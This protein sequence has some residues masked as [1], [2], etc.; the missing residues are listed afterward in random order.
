MAEEQIQVGATCLT[1]SSHFTF[2]SVRTDANS[3]VLQ[4]VFA[5]RY[6][7]YCLERKFL[8]VEPYPDGLESDEYDQC[9]THFAACNR[10]DQVVGTLRLI[11]PR[12]DQV[13][14]F[15]LF[16]NALYENFA[17]PPKHESGEV[18][19]L[20]VDRN[21]H[22]RKGDTPEGI[23]QEFLQNPVPPKVMNHQS[24]PTE[25]RSNS[26]EILLGLY[27]QLYHHALETGVRYWYAA[28]EQSLARL[29][30]RV[31]FTFHPIGFQTEY[32]GP[33]TPFVADLRELESSLAARNPELFAWFL[34]KE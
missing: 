8:P 29:L 9:S 27:R 32:Y 12:D 22:R 24:P 1:N 28:M 15:E 3:S 23:S 5:L 13:F 30:G 20:I 25:R 6:R 17:P 2:C 4:E 34:Q 19:R 18:S 33:V 10:D 7:V 21:Y 16:C 26:P 11:Q 14:P 31:G